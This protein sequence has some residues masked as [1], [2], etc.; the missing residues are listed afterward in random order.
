MITIGVTKCQ[1]GDT[2]L[3]YRK[4]LET[5][6]VKIVDLWDFK[7]NRE[8]LDEN[9]SK[10]DGILF[11][12]GP[13]VSPDYYGEKLFETVSSKKIDILRDS[14]EK[15][16]YRYMS[17]YKLPTLAICR[18]LQVISVMEGS[19]L[20]QDILLENKGFINHSKVD[21]KDTMHHIIWNGSKNIKGKYNN[22]EVNSAHHQ[23]C[24]SVPE[25]FNLV[26]IS[27][28]GIVEAFELDDEQYMLCVQ[29]HPERIPNREIS[30]KIKESFLYR[31][32]Q[33]KKNLH[34]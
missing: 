15:Y 19:K 3:N 14:H 7:D 26:A 29:W 22:I 10:I 18:G 33:Y 32:N 23:S 9:L 16:I 25:G 27:D 28:D 5:D 4:W 17:K 2:Y 34:L 12:G 21:N 6:D 8:A 30:K 1:G 31:V 13:D 24:I 11:T 20:Y